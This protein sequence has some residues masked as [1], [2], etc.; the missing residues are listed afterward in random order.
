MA[1]I[2]AREISYSADGLEMVAYLAWDADREGPRP[3]VIVVHEWWGANDY[4]RGR[5]EQL[6]ELGY[7][8]FAVDLYGGGRIAADPDEAGRLMN[9][10]VGDLPAMRARFMAGLERLRSEPLV[11]GSK[12]AAI[13]YCMGGGI[14]LHMACHGADLAAVASF[15]GALPLA[16]AGLEGPARV[17]A[18]L[19]VYHG[20]ADEFVSL[21]DARAFR[22]AMD[23]AD[24]DLLFVLLPGATHGFTNPAATE[25]GKKYGL[26]LRYSALA[27]SASWDHM[28]LVLGEALA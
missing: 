3:G 5:A 4:V 10:L 1:N 6:A 2:Q 8:G 16:T 27:D 24:A 15:H 22:R 25:R 28:Q 21:D 20:E 12:T 9:G 14:V 19:A 26:P 17:S 7:A 18:R 11:N 23:A 13:G